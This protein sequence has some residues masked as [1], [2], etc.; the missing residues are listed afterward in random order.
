MID[1]ARLPADVS[2]RLGRHTWRSLEAFHGMIYFSPDAAARYQ[3]LGLTGRS[4]YFAS[5]AAAMGPASAEAVIATFYNFNPELVRSALPAAWQV[6]SPESVRAARIAGADT[7]LRQVLG[8]AVDSPEMA[9]AA[10]P[11]GARRKR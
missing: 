6:T 8:Q 4:G 2:P 5:R 7:T 10:S 11:P 1:P 3:A 9:R